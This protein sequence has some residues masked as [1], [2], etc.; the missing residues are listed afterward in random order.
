MPSVIQR[1]RIL[2]MAEYLEKLSP[3]RFNMWNTAMFDNAG[4]LIRGCVAGH[5]PRV[6][7][8]ELRFCETAPKHDQTNL[9]NVKT[10]EVDHAA[11]LC[12]AFYG[13]DEDLFYAGCVKYGG[14]ES[15]KEVAKYWRKL[16]TPV[17][18][19]KLVIVRKKLS[20]K[21]TAHR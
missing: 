2:K 4:K 18:R 5:T 10:G 17:K 14:K 8:K 21:K 19:K 20:R 3:K 11:K 6:F 7:P 16:A 1:A 13:L 15:V 9:C 12:A